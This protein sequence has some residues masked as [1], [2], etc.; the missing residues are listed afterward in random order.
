MNSFAPGSR[1]ARERKPWWR[2]A[3][4]ELPDSRWLLIALLI[5]VVA[6]LGAVLFF[7]AIVYCN[8]FFLGFLVG[9]VPPS[10]NGEGNAGVTSIARPWLL[11]VVVGLGGLISGALVFIWA[12]EA[13]G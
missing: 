4:L 10:P 1:S 13:E 5:G 12:P 2:H 7:N 11:P 8:R 9:Y 3:T 6:G